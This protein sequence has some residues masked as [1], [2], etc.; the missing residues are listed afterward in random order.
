M[1][2]S[3]LFRQPEEQPAGFGGIVMAAIRFI[4]PVAD[5]SA[6]IV[7]FIVSDPQVAV[8]DLFTIRPADIKVLDRQPFLIGL[9]VQSPCQA[10]KDLIAF[11]VGSV[12]K[13]HF[14]TS[15]FSS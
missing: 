10:E 13:F 11:Q 6:D 7:L 5:I 2:H 14:S 8:T 1:V 9:C 12:K 4:D 15:T 3:V